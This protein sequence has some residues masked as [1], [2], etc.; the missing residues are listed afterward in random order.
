MQASSVSSSRLPPSRSNFSSGFI[1]VIRSPDGASAKSGIRAARKDRPALRG[2]CHRAAPRADRW[3]DAGYGLLIT[4]RRRAAAPRTTKTQNRR[5]QTG[6]VISRR[7][8]PRPAIVS[9]VAIRAAVVAV[10]VGGVGIAVGR[11][12][13][14]VIAWVVVVRARIVG[15]RE[16]GTN[17]RA[18]CEG[19][20]PPAPAPE[21]PGLRV[22]RRGNRGCR[23][24]ARQY[25][26]SERSFHGVLPCFITAHTNLRPHGININ[27][28][29]VGLK[30]RARD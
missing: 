16:C 25:Q 11:V 27:P 28:D 10:G 7:A 1:A 12:G 9:V 26:C 30:E 20:E 21:P 14:A 6:S 15:T 24:A 22:C 23:Q 3:L 18:E 5:A 8:A 17:E 2:A 13:I 19:S 4:A 29:Q